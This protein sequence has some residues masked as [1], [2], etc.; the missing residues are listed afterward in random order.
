[1]WHL[2][3]PLDAPA[4]AMHVATHVCATQRAKSSA[5]RLGCADSV[6]ALSYTSQ[7]A[8]PR[9]LSSTHLCFASQVAGD[10][11]NSSP[12]QCLEHT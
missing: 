9:R 11:E 6:H 1:M 12:C 4:V 3:P 8:R 10:S 2:L 7:V 5:L